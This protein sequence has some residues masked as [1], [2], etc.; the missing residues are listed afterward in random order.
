[1]YLQF[2]TRIKLGRFPAQNGHPQNFDIH[3]EFYFVKCIFG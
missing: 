1:M 3:Y 2:I